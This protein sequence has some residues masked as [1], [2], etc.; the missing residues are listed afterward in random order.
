MLFLQLMVLKIFHLISWFFDVS[1]CIFIDIFQAILC[2]VFHFHVLCFR[3]LLRIWVH[4]LSIEDLVQMSF[5]LFTPFIDISVFALDKNSHDSR[6]FLSCKW[7]S[8]TAFTVFL[9]ICHLVK[10]T[11]FYFC[12]FWHANWI[13]WSLTWILYCHFLFPGSFYSFEYFTH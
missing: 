4:K 11:F 12:I 8:C 3:I 13:L 9:Y 6:N 5:W 1:I 10:M 7:K 2:F